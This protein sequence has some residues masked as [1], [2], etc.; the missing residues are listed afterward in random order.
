[1]PEQ[2]KDNRN[3]TYVLALTLGKTREVRAKLPCDL[4]NENDWKLLM[5]SLADRLAYV[6]WLVADQAREDEITL[7]EFEER[8]T[9]KGI[10]DAASDAFIAELGNFYQ[11][12][13]QTKLLTMTQQL[14][15]AMQNERKL[16]SSEKF[17]QVIEHAISG[18][19]SSS[20]QPMQELTG[21]S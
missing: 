16:T 11:K 2:F 7:E 8:L 1:M 14:L 18:A 21:T 6:W 10:A 17:E 13:D 5:S 20:L 9:G 19:M 12:Y 3:K 4:F 15:K